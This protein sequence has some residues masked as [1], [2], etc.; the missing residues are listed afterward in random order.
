M[1]DLYNYKCV[2]DR[3]VDGDT[4]DAEVIDLG[5]GH[6]FH[7]IPE[8]PLRFRLAAVNAYETSLRQ[9]TTPEQKEIGL[10]A[11]EWLANLIEGKTIRI[12]T[13]RAGAKGSL[14]RFLAWLYLDDDNPMEPEYS[15]NRMLLDN[16]FAVVSKYPDGEVFIAMGYARPTNED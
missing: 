5:F 11:K 8:A 12:H 13:V 1:G 16:G 7:S 14:G 10:K 3:V 9:G 15:I 6:Y 2:C 4:I